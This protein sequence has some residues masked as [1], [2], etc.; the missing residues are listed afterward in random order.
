MNPQSVPTDMATLADRLPGE[1]DHPAWATGIA[2]FL[3]YGV[4]LTAMTL[5]LFVVPWLLFSSL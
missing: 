1:Y 5:L 4:I 2:T 3:G